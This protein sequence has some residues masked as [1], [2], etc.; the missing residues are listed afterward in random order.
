MLLCQ[1]MGSSFVDMVFASGGTIPI[2]HYSP[3]ALFTLEALIAVN[4][5]Y[6]LAAFNFKGVFASFTDA[7]QAK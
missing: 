3:I 7:L 4:F 2:Y 6:L 5:T 1:G